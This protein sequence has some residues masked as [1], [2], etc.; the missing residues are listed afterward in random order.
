MLP[1]QQSPETSER[2]D[3]L[4]GRRISRRSL[5][6]KALAVGVTLPAVATL[7]AACGSDDEDPTATTAAEATAT[8][9]G[10]TDPT[11]TTAMDEPTATVAVEE[12]TATEAMAEP[13]ATEA[14]AEPTPT[15]GMA[16][17]TELYGF[18]IEPA[19]N[20]GG[21]V[22]W[23]TRTGLMAGSLL[24]GP[25]PPHVF[26]TPTE[27]H[28]ETFE[29]MPL[30][31]ESWEFNDDGTV[32]TFVFRDGVTFHDGEVMD[33]EDVAF[34]IALTAVVG[35]GWPNIN[36]ATVTTPDATTV[37]LTFASTTVNVAVDFAR[38]GIHAA[39]VLS[40]LD[41]ANTD[42]TFYESHP[43][44][45]G[46]DISLVIG[47][48][49][50]QYTELVLDDFERLTRYDD[51][52]RGA[53]HLD[54][55]VFKSV[56]S[57]DLYPALLASGEIDI[58]GS[59][60]FSSLDPSQVGQFD[61]GIADVVE[62]AGAAFHVFQMNMFPDRPLFQDVRVRRA[63]LLAVDREALVE[64]VLFGYGEVAPVTTAFAWSYDPAGITAV[65]PYDPEQAAVL[66]DEAGFV[67]GDDG[68]RA[69]GDLRLEF[70]TW[71]TAGNTIQQTAATVLQEYWR[72]IGVVT[73]VQSEDGPALFDRVLA[74]DYDMA[75]W[76][77]GSDVDQRGF[78]ACEGSISAER[79]GYCNEELAALMDA[80][81]SE[82]DPDARLELQTQVF[83]FIM[84]DLPVGPLYILNGL[85]AISTRVHNV[86]PYGANYDYGWNAFTWWVDA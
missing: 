16:E 65:Y 77:F 26:E 55:L 78:Y 58:A 7:L 43:A 85:T 47:T 50:F 84:E 28:P 70:T 62:Y 33:S 1:D 37:E 34:S 75:V 20:V 18:P 32:W 51:Y 67:L 39:H 24:F 19:Q 35:W 29:P 5:V 9:G 17:I 2:V 72:A 69:N 46:E 52:W 76:N 49:P 74:S 6:T 86:I 59:G 73:D 27:P 81:A 83:N 82:L 8:T 38:Y 66:L 71:F 53:P 60:A 14:M 25:Y 13:T 68:V 48:G 54:E 80:A 22:V 4:A 44:N 3:G 63:L 11:A 64:A 31:A 41:L 15:E 36:G 23:G 40:D 21:T 42:Y 30:L 79:F 56:A 45:T 10:G 57:A 12:P 61:A